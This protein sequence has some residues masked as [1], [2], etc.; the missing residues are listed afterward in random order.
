MQVTLRVLSGPHAGRSFIFDQHDTFLIGRSDTAHLCLPEDRF[1]SR[2]HCL[3]EIAPPRCF[4]RDLGSTNGTYV[5]GQKVQEA[6]LR[7]GDRIQGGQTVLAVEVSAEQLQ[8]TQYAGHVELPPTQ[9]A[10]VMVECLNCGAR[11]QAEAASPDERLSFLCEDCRVELRKR[12]QPIPG[13]EM[14]KVLGRGGMGCVMLARNEQTGETVAIKTLLPEVAVSDQAL[15]RFMREIDVASSLQHPHIVRFIDRGTNKGV[16]YLI[17]EFVEGADA[18]KLADARGGRLPFQET[19]TIISQSLDALA[20]AHSHGYIHRDIKDQNILVSGTWPDYNSKLTDFGLA[21]SF[22]QTG[23]SGVTMAG[24][25]AGTFTY[26]PPE[27]IRD[28]RNV[29]PISDIYAMGMT[30]YSLLTGTVALDISPRANVAE[31]VKAIFEKP[32]IPVRQRVPEIPEAVATV[33]ERAIA[34]DPAQRW[35]TAE[36]MRAALLQSV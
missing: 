10:I 8:P 20:F 16:V 29:R 3:L 12:P 25:V 11:D 5:N 21:K 31:T 26:M 14:V 4:L 13:Y 18:A 35:P 28:F 2:N 27:Q 19:V 24:D 6:Y 32:I 9:P 17:T 30:A 22:T 36:A 7:N 23:M 1:F 34:K 15:R 33:I